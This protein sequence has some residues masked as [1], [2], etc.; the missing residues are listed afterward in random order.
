MFGPVMGR[1]TEQTA[2]YAVGQISPPLQP[3]RCPLVC[4]VGDCAFARTDERMN[5]DRSGNCDR[6]DDDE[7]QKYVNHDFCDLHQCLQPGWHPSMSNQ[8]LVPGTI[9]G[10]RTRNTPEPRM[11]STR[12]ISESLFPLTDRRQ[13]ISSPISPA[14]GQ[15]LLPNFFFS[16]NG[17]YW[18]PGRRLARTSDG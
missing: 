18:Q 17:V 11:A 3:L 1:V 9:P 13:V 16:G 2:R 4:S 14:T 15:V 10:A 8:E 6:R 7:R 5:S 12:L